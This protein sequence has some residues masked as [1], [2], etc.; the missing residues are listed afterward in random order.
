[1]KPIIWSDLAWRSFLEVQDFLETNWGQKITDKFI[2]ESER[3]ISMIRKNNGL[4][5]KD[6]LFDCRKCVI[7]PNTSLYYLEEEA[8]IRLL[9]F[10][11]NRQDPEK[12]KEF[13]V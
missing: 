13:L 10:W 2:D 9:L 3:F 11:D 8:C 6:E 7:H 1:M 5:Q 12:L 4:G